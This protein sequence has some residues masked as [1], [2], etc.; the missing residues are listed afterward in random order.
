[1][2][3]VLPNLRYVGKDRAHAL[4]RCLR[5][6]DCDEYLSACKSCF[7]DGKHAITKAIQF[8]PVLKHWFVEANLRSNARTR[9]TTRVADFA[10]AKQRYD[11]IAQPLGRVILFIESLLAVANLTLS[12]RPKDIAASQFLSFLDNESYIQAAKY[13]HFQ[14][15]C[16]LTWGHRVLGGGRTSQ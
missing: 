10:W 5:P 4:R 14:N 15:T 11:G 6:W 13:G 7:V 12:M 1:M 9:I 3:A 16:S 8:S 2:S